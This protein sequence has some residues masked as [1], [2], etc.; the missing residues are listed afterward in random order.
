VQELSIEKDKKGGLS[1]GGVGR[2][3]GTRQKREGPL[4]QEDKAATKA[5]IQEAKKK[6]LTRALG[7]T[8]PRGRENTT[9]LLLTS[10][11]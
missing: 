6:K 2:L 9:L 5:H 1:G 7:E 11:P 4:G 3:V 10:S 8:S